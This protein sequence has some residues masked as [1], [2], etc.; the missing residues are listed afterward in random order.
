MSDVVV[1]VPKAAGWHWLS[2][3]DLAGQPWDGCTQYGFTV[4]S[5]PKISEG[6]RVY[7]VSHGRLRGF[8]LLK[9]IGKG[10]HFG[11]S[12]KSVALVRWGDAR[13]VTIPEEIPGFRGYRYR[14]WDRADELPFEEWMKP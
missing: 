2:E 7:V 9:R 4:S 1:T 14:W 6:E 11:G 3:G 5:L 8:S 13:A 12:E 10:K